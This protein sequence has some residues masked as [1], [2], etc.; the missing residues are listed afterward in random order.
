MAGWVRTL[1]V[2]QEWETHDEDMKTLF[3]C[4]SRVS[5]WRKFECRRGSWWIDFVHG[6]WGEFSIDR[7]IQSFDKQ[8]E[9]G[10]I[11]SSFWDEMR[12]FYWMVVRRMEGRW[13][14]N[15]EKI[16]NTSSADRIAGES[17]FT[18]VF[19]RFNFGVMKRSKKENKGSNWNLKFADSRYL[20]Y[21]DIN[22]TWKMV[23]RYEEIYIYLKRVMNLNP[24][25]SIKR[26]SMHLCNSKILDGRHGNVHKIWQLRK[27]LLIAGI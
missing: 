22:E 8:E 20:F 23:A 6:G 4:E 19:K 14:F 17:P 15:I 26:R 18:F 9:G 24:F 7:S 12:R 11:Y 13:L 16:F 21:I 2:E 1:S 10:R 5:R 27:H 25:R 3:R